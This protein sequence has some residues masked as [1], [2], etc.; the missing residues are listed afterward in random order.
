MVFPL[1]PSEAP[2]STLTLTTTASFASFRINHSF[3]ML[4][5]GPIH[6]YSRDDKTYSISES[7]K[8]I[9]RTLGAVSRH[10]LDGVGV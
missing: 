10:E 7:R 2:D 8:K 9:V 3:I 6:S 1:S 5:F 4:P